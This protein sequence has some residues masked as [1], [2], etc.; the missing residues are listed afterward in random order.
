MPPLSL[1]RPAVTRTSSPQLETLTAS[2]E[3]PPSHTDWHVYFRVRFNGLGS[4]RVNE[5]VIQRGRIRA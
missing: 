5:L 1:T 4:L 2:F 3:L